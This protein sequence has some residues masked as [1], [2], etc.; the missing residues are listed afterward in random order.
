MIGVAQ[1]G[2]AHLLAGHVAEARPLLESGAKVC[3]A[4][5]DPI[6]HTR[7]QLY[8][9]LAREQADDRAGACAAFGVVLQRWGG[10]K[11][12]RTAAVAREHAAKLR[13]AKTRD[14]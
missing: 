10:A 9:G 5:E 4:L 6:A 11:V 7:A 2:E 13:C 3:R 12:S 1:L 8:L 14:D